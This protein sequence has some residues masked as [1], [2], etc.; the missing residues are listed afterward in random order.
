MKGIITMLIACCFT[1]CSYSQEASL[2]E[3]EA[4]VAGKNKGDISKKI[5]LSQT[6]ILP[7][8]THT[9]TNIPF[10]YLITK[11]T[12][13]VIRNNKVML[14]RKVAGDKFDDTIETIFNNTLSG[15]IISITDIYC[16]ISPM[17]KTVMLYPIK[18]TIRD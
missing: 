17:D 4:F 3:L 1:I 14:T 11:F 13:Q 12:I 9:T 6:G 8:V 2:P 5:L 10:K 16:S 18:L 15:D 7:R